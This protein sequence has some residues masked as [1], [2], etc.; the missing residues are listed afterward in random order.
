MGVYQGSPGPQLPG[1]GKEGGR[2]R[3]TFANLLSKNQVDYQNPGGKSALPS[4]D[5]A[6]TANYYQQLAGLYAG[7]QNQRAAFKL[8]RVGFRAGFQEAKAGIRAEKL[9][10]LAGTENAA[11]ERGIAGSS[12]DLQGRADV[13]GA[14]AAAKVSAK[15]QMLQGVAGTRIGEQ[16]AAI[17]YFMGAAGLEANKLAQQQQMLAQQ[18]E[19]NTI[20]SGQESQMDI[21]KQMYEAQLAMYS[22]G[23]EPGKRKKQPL[24]GAA[25]GDYYGEP[26][27]RGY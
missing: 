12:A 18:L 20:I 15:N 24:I 4:L 3:N 25:L 1:L 17:E 19:Q 16:G 2:K 6:S 26:I 21:I 9:A 7:Y 5:P 8:Q 10:G 13:R 14:A 22:N 23:L 11:I 27:N